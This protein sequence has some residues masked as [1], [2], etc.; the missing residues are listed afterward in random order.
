M[1]E[2]T[3]FLLLLGLTM[4]II[5]AIAS[6]VFYVWEDPRIIEVMDA[7]PGANCGGCGY[8]GCAAAAEAIVSGKAEASICVAGGF[9]TAQ[10]VAAVMGVSVEAKEPQIAWTSCT[11]G[12]GDAD[13][14]YT[15]N[16]ARDC[17]A[18]ALLYGGS[19]LCP[20]GCIGLGTCAKVCPFDAI[21]M[22]ADNLPIVDPQKCVACGTC[23]RECPK[24]II[25]LTSSTH[26][27]VHEYSTD[28][29]TAPCQRTCPTGINIPGYIRAIRNGD[30]AEAVRVIKEKCPLPL[31]CGRICPAPCELE[32]RRILADEP[33]AINPLKR[34]V[35]EYEMG[36]G[37]HIQPYKAASS[38][39]RTAVIGGGS[40][41]LT[42]AY[43]LARLG[44]DPTIF[45]AMPE[46]GGILRYVITADRLPREVLD[47]EIAGIL[48]MGVEARTAQVLGRDFSIS[49]LLEEGFEA[50]ALTIGGFDSRK[51]LRPG[52]D[53]QP[54]AG[55]RLM[56]DLLDAQARERPL[57]GGRHLV[58]IDGGL[59][60]LELARAARA[61]GTE[62]VTLVTHRPADDLPSE[63]RDYRRELAAEGITV[64]WRT[65]VRGL[66]GVR[67]KLTR[68][69]YEEVDA[70][71]GLEPER[72]SAPL[73]TLVL[74]AGRLPELVI[75]HEPIEEAPQAEAQPQSQAP[76][77]AGEGPAE[78][79]EP[80]AWDGRW[81]TIETFRTLPGG[82]EMGIFTPPEPGRVS[83]SEAVIKS[84]L[85]GRRIV[86]G[87]QQFFAGEAIASPPHPVV[88]ADTVLDVDAVH[89]VATSHRER[90]PLPHPTAGTEND[91]TAEE[92]VPGLDEEAAR[93]ESQRCLACGLICY[94]KDVQEEKALF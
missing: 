76:A 36:T 20:I 85:S 27:I 16:G 69:D 4:A 14:I 19:K 64:K 1:L 91:W 67:E 13:P 86:R 92:E 11:Y 35:S 87:I 49:G 33:V 30:Y 75:A 12:V 84:I 45:E 38:G 43:Y 58:I 78:T 52:A 39:K 93:R 17:R 88:E 44:H 18:A 22:G 10:M 74:A 25:T 55:V 15:Y 3:L 34:F 63:L 23:V 5:L 41:G 31:I 68:I 61:E 46:L 48:D 2:A 72:E 81:R 32:C 54:L 73:D 24:D 57:E 29:C 21:R 80:P 82:G 8:A 79:D 51:I 47:H 89:H 62:T 37:Q 53:E 77:T 60:G 9:E 28:E 56:F 94:R 6:R 42:A 7:L 40:E 71:A 59:K 66:R 90:A 83:D 65:R 26:R 70:I 50:V